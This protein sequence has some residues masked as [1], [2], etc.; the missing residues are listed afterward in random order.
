MLEDGLAVPGRY[1][2]ICPSRRTT[3]ISKTELDPKALKGSAY[4]II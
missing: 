4:A 1:T 3:E 2:A